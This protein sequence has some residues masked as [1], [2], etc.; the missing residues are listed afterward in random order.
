VGVAVVCV[1]ALAQADEESPT[2]LRRESSTDLR[3][4]ANF[5]CWKWSQSFVTASG[6]TTLADGEK[7]KKVTCPAGITQCAH[8]RLIGTMQTSGQNV[9]IQ[10]TYGDCA[11][12]EDTGRKVDCAGIK[13]DMEK[14]M[15]GGSVSTWKC[16]VC[17]SDNCNYNGPQTDYEL[18]SNVQ[19]YIRKAVQTYQEPTCDNDG[20]DDDEGLQPCLSVVGQAFAIVFLAILMIMCVGIQLLFGQRKPL[21]KPE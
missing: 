18:R 14:S 11:A 19:Y 7:A 3:R 1:Y 17:D 4:A 9:P 15:Q 5:S 21:P 10:L 8:M 12:D 6:D 13:K 20:T 2:Y 16:G